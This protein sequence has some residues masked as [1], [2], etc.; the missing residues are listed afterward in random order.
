M[1]ILVAVAAV[2]FGYDAVDAAKVL[3]AILAVL[4]LLNITPELR[5]KGFK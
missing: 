1:S 4:N 3:G 5:A 2:Q